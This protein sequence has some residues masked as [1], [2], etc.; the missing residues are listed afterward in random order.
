MAGNMFIAT[1][2]AKFGG[3]AKFA[4][5]LIEA[6]NASERWRALAAVF[7]EVS[8]ISLIMDKCK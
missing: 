1:K 2:I 4:K 5:M 3:V 8:G 7:G 6:R